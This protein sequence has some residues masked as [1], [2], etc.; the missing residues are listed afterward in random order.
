MS[1]NQV[2]RNDY[3]IA[4]SQEVQANFEAAASALEAALS[5]RDGD[6]RAAMAAYSADGVSDRYQAM[7]TQWNNAG[8]EVRNVIQSIRGSLSS[9]DDIAHRALSQAAAAIPD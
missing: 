3:S 2:D 5:R 4:S 8:Q 7:E 6:V 9:N 1:G